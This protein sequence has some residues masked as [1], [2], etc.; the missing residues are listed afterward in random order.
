LDIEHNNGGLIYVLL[1]DHAVEI[2]SDRGIYSKADMSA[3]NVIC[4]EIE[5]KFSLNQY[6]DGVLSG[7]EILTQLLQIQ[8]PRTSPS[9][10]EIPNELVLLG[11]K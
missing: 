8:F 7:I 9:D 10:N 6:R 1:A 11:I 3:W 2:V 5:L 4:R